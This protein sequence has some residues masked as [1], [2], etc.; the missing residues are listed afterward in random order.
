MK[1]A[2]TRIL[3]AALFVMSLSGIASAQGAIRGTAQVATSAPTM[4]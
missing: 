3:I 2:D 1:N 4:F